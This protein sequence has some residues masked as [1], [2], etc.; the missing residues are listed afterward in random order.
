LRLKTPKARELPLELQ[1]IEGRRAL[2]Q[3]LSSM[4]THTASACRFIA[5]TGFRR[6]EGTALRQNNF[7]N[8]FALEMQS[9]SRKL[10][11]PLSRQALALLHPSGPGR[12][13]R[14]AEFQLRKPLIRIFGERPTPQGARACV[15]P[16]DLRR[17]FKTVGT[18]LGID[19]TILN[20]LVGHSL[21]GVNK[22]YIAN[23]RLSVLHA[24]TQRISD[25][26]DNPQEF[27]VNSTLPT[28]VTIA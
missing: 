21:R 28:L 25:E 19:P 14:V 22:H 7:V 3:E 5:Y 10:Q 16:H 18:E 11:V 2:I 17:Y 23:L 12:L 8:S 13:L 26:I 27:P 9:K 4:R 1:T 24:A 20:L 15:T 6:R